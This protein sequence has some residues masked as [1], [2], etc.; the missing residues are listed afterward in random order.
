ML[1]DRSLGR[2]DGTLETHKKIQ[3]K[4]MEYGAFLEDAYAILEKA[5]ENS[6]VKVIKTTKNRVYSFYC[7]SYDSEEIGFEQMLEQMRE[8]NDTRIAYITVLESKWS[9]SVLS[10]DCRN[11]LR[12]L[13]PDN[14]YAENISLRLGSAPAF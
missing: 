13:H 9:F 4:A 11:K 7:L 12:D 1:Y 8:T 10:A 14:I 3:K 2:L 5:P 6:I